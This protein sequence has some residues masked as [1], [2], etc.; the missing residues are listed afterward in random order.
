MANID[1]LDFLNLNTL[2]SYPIREDVS[3]ISID[4]AF[5]IPNDFIA[6]FQL[7]ATYDP[8]KRFYI[9][10]LSNFEANI[11]IEVSDDANIVVGLITIDTATHSQYKK[12]YL[13]ASDDYVD[14][15]GVITIGNLA[16]IQEQPTGNFT[17]TLVLTE[18][19]TRTIIP[20]IQGVNRMTFKNADGSSFSKSGNITLIAR[21]NLRFNDL[22]GGRI[23]IDAGENLGLN[24]LC[25]DTLPCIK[26]INGIGP[27]GVGNFTLDFSDCANLTP[28]PANTGLLLQDICC[29]P[30]TGCSDIEELTNRLTAT[31][32]QLLALKDYYQSLST[33]FENFKTTVSYTCNC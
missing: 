2:R 1:N 31:E 12:Y 5:S 17:F 3:G 27:D 9:S 11:T 28:I 14:A 7:A 15:T 10:E 32:S 19:E 25:A 29:K 21:T 6:D 16:G 13:V 26:T 4:A 23:V 8:S 33:L 22:G 24:I 20:S 30:C 18:F